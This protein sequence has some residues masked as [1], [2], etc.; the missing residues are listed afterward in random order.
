VASGRRGSHITSKALSR[1]RR[2]QN[3]NKAMIE[4]ENNL[5]SGVLEGGRVLK[6]G[7]KRSCCN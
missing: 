4:T 7:L 3:I 1:V 5:C 2:L 6:T